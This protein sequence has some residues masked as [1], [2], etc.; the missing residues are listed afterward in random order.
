LSNWERKTKGS[1][2][3]FT[4]DEYRARYDKEMN[5]LKEKGFC[6]YFL[7]VADYVKY[8]KD[9]RVLVG[10]GRGSG[11]GSLVAYLSDITEVDPV[12]AELLFERFLTPGRKAL[13]DFDIDFPTSRSDFMADYIRNKYGADRVVQVGTVL[14]LRNKGAIRDS[15]RFFSAKLEPAEA[16]DMWKDVDAISKII[17]DAEAGTA[18][19]GLSWEELWTQYD[20]EL[21]PYRV[22]W[23][24]W[25]ATAD[26][27]VGRVKSYGKHAAG[28]V[29]ST[30]EP[31]TDWLPMRMGDV[32]RAARHHHRSV[33]LAG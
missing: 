29:I 13:P 27:L 16:S 6:G 33:Q 10:P 12:E 28:I 11:G 17:T 31:L 8:A 25:I 30:G 23:P 1:G 26:R 32:L 18:G 5:L 21:N 24:E 7:I 4:Q 14:R 22:K 9:N 19:L 3:R 20:V 15:A 2:K